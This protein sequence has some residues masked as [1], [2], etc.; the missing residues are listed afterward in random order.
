MQQGKVIQLNFRIFIIF[1]H[2]VFE[3]V[4]I[5]ERCP[6]CNH[7]FQFNLLQSGETVANPSQ[8]SPF[9]YTIQKTV[10]FELQPVAVFF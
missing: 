7:P 8:G 5:E 2:C 6:Y 9:P 3:K 10:H 4:F 1:L